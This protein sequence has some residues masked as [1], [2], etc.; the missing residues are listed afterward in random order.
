MDA[1]SKPRRFLFR[2]DEDESG[3]SGT[4]Y[5]AEG[6]QFTDGRCAVRWRTDRASVAVYDSIEDVEFIHGHNGK[7]SIVWIDGPEAAAEEPV[8]NHVHVNVDT[9]QLVKYVSDRM[10]RMFFDEAKQGS[11]YR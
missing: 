2:R 10:L 9:E 1:V 8:E 6:V 4:G 3:I 11:R 5:V 7:T